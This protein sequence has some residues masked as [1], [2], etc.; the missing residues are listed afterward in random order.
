ME[1]R[2]VPGPV[3]RT[4]DEL[5]LWLDAETQRIANTIMRCA[6]LPVSNAAPERPR[7]GMMRY[8]DGTGWDPGSGEGLYVYKTAG[9]TFIV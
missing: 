3:P 8:A 1:R 2:Y 7:V 4:Y 5:R 9:W 6:D